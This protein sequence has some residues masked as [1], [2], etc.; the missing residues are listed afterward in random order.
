MT[1]SKPC[2]HCGQSH[3]NSSGFCSDFCAKCVDLQRVVVTKTGAV[4]KSE[5]LISGLHLQGDFVSIVTDSRH[6]IGGGGSEGATGGRGGL[7]VSRL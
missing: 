3:Y 6:P 1:F 5:G 4:G 2:G 7:K